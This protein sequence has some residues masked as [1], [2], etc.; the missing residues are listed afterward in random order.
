MLLCISMLC[1]LNYF[2]RDRF[3]S[4]IKIKYFGQSVST[5][6]VFSFQFCKIFSQNLQIKSL[7]LL[8]K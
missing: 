1:V 4:A 7:F 3:I 2:A 5:S 8:S 6:I